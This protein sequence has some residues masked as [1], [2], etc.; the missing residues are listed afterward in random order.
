MRLIASGSSSILFTVPRWGR[1]SPIRLPRNE[2]RRKRP[3][4]G[5]KRPPSQERFHKPCASVHLDVVALVLL[6]LLR[7]ILPHEALLL[8]DL[9]E[10]LLHARLHCHIPGCPVVRLARKSRTPLPGNGHAG[11]LFAK[12]TPAFTGMVSWTATPR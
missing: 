2:K 5:T 12:E 11:K 10:A 4:E 1:K 3:S 7:I 9:A 6:H 8:R